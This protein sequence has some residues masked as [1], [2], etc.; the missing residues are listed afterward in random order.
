MIE[1]ALLATAVLLLAAVVVL[2]LQAERLRGEIAALERNAA[3]ERA[4]AQAEARAIEQAITRAVDEIAQNFLREVDDAQA[5]ADGVIADL[6]AGNVRLRQEW[7]G[8]EAARLSDAATAAAELDELA[9]LRA[10][11]VADLVRF[12]SEC[13]ARIRG[14]QSVI[15]AYTDVAGR[16]ELKR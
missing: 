3:I 2:A 14:L 8:C 15:R 6:H 16:S 7:R 13:D 9:E 10:A 1:R 12:G 5:K 4:D 11:G